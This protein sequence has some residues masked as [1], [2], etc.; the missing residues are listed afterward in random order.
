MKLSLLL[1]TALFAASSQAAD[2]LQFRGPNA[3]AVSPEATPPGPSVGIAWSADLPGRGLSSPI[4]V[5]DRVFVTCSSG[6]DQSNLHVFCFNAADGKPRWQRVMKA[7]GRTMSHN[8]TNVAA[9]TPCSDGER[10]FA[11]YSSNDLFAFDLEGN[12]LWLRGLTFDYANASNSL[13]MA[14]SPVVVGDTLIVQSENDSESLAVGIDVKTGINR[15]KK[16]RPKSANWTSA[17]VYKEAVALQSSKGL[18]GIEPKTGKV[19]WDYTDGASTTPSSAV[20]RNAIY[21][22]SNGVTALAPEN[23]AASQLWRADGL[24]PGTG[25]PL[26]LEDALYVL[27]GSGVLIKAST[28]DGDEAWKL[29]LTGPFS[30]SPVGA[31]KYIYIA[32]ERGHFQVV[33]TTAAEGEI[34]HTLDLKDTIL[35]TPAISNGAVYVRSDKKLWK[36]K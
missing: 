32:G 9:P 34:I 35:C 16:E 5:S 22:P 7:T 19:L 13:G 21:V 29:R 26:V 3:S 20:T 30:G 6:P 25:S 4:I 8:K 2:W 23:G 24:K 27:N 17:V 15:W 1:L 10:V 33:D 31:G 18:T 14:S 11:L 36:L 28:R 12:L